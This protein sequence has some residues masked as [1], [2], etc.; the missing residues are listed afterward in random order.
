[1][2]I[3][4]LGHSCFVL[5]SGGFRVLLDPYREVQ[6]LQ[7]IETEADAVYCSHGHFDHA[8][9]ANVRLTSGKAN[10]FAVHEVPTF[11]DGQGGALRGPNTVRKFTAEGVSVA[12]MGDLGHPLSQAQLADLGH[13]DVLLIPV[14][15]YFT[16][17]APTAKA[18]ADAV[19]AAVVVPMHYRNGPVG[20][21]VLGTLEDF[22][23][24][25]PAEQV[26]R[27]GPT[28]TAEPGMPRQVA[29]L[30]LA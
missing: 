3:T 6:G 20:F 9:T 22:T 14:G 16:I 13:C 7:D 4:W 19:G 17:D 23:G 21:D 18:V 27:Y 1:M 11:H 26:K 29:V 28:L 24:L 5:E 8:H 30:S 12:H 25:Y 2:T 15:G 10:P